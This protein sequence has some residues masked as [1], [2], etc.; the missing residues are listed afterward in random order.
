VGE[1]Q[2]WVRGSVTTRGCKARRQQEPAPCS[3]LSYANAC[4]PFYAKPTLPSYAKPLQPSHHSSTNWSTNQCATRRLQ[5][6]P[7]PPLL[8]CSSTAMGCR[9]QMVLP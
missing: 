2:A 9:P 5:T 4:W 1:H 3:R 8:T 6:L 7:G